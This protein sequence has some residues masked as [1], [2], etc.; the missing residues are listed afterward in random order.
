M[1]HIACIIFIFI[2]GH[3]LAQD[4]DTIDFIHKYRQGVKYDVRTTQ[5]SVRGYLIRETFATVV[6]ED[7]QQSHIHEFLKSSIVSMKPV[8]DRRVLKEDILG[9]NYHAHTYLFSSSSIVFDEPRNYINY[10]WLLVENLNYGLTKN[11]EVTV[12]TVFLYPISLGVKCKYEIAPDTYIGGNVFA[13][14][15]ISSRFTPA[16]FFG[17][18]ALARITKGTSNNNFSFSGGVLGLNSDVLQIASKNTMINLP[19]ANVSYANRF[20]ES[21]A[22]CLEGW[23]FPEVQSGFA[24]AGF[25]FLRSQQTSYTFGCFTYVNTV[26]NKITPNLKTMPIPYIGVTSNF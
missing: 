16:F 17:Y 20:H 26:N 10:Q 3:C 18:G 24:G 21:W 12:N 25:K 14:G 8:Q 1:K 15:N 5:N 4:A 23:Y 6:I 22:L 19:F 13:V 9:E 7:R 11:W 2:A